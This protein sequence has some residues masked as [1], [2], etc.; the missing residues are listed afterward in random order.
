[1]PASEH[2]RVTNEGG[3]GAEYHAAPRGPRRALLGR[4]LATVA[5]VAVAIVATPWYAP[6]LLPGVAAVVRATAPAGRYRVEGLALLSRPGRHAPEFSLTTNVRAAGSGTASARLVTHKSA[7]GPL[8]T[9]VIVLALSIWWRDARRWLRRLAFAAVAAYALGVVEVGLSI[10][11]TSALT[12]AEL[13]GNP[14]AVP[15]LARWADFAEA[16]G[17]IVIALS[18]GVL[19][20]AASTRFSRVEP[21]PPSR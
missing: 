5:L 3:D 19:V 4:L 8:R 10:Q 12:A 7:A 16:G 9:L 14:D 1:V 6:L 11:G 15:L 2:V 17:S 18:I 21:A 13:S 20:C